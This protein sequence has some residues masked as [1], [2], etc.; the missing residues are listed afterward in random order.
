MPMSLPRD[1][2]DRVVRTCE[3]HRASK[4]NYQSLHAIQSGPNWANRP[5]VYRAL[6]SCP[7]VAL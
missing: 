1:I 7:K 5:S 6:E 3:Y 2:L 4:E